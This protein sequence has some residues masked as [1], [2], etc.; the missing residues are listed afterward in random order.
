MQVIEVQV[1]GLHGH[2]DA[3]FALRDRLTLLTG[4]NG[5]GKTSI[6]RAINALLALDL[7]ELW[8]LEFVR[9]GV[10][11]IADE[12]AQWLRVHKGDGYLRF[13]I[14]HLAESFEL[15]RRIISVHEGREISEGVEY[16]TASH[17]RIRY[18]RRYFQKHIKKPIYVDLERRLDD[19]S[20]P[21]RHRSRFSRTERGDDPKPISAAVRL[22]Q[23]AHS[24]TRAASQGLLEE[25]K[26]KMILIAMERPTASPTL[27]IDI[28]G[29]RR[30]VNHRKEI[31]RTLVSTGV[32]EPELAQ[33]LDELSADCA[34]LLKELDTTSE[35]LHSLLTS[36][37][38]RLQQLAVR[39]YVLEDQIAR[40]NRVI[41]AVKEF[42]ER[43]SSVEQPVDYYKELVNSFIRESGKEIHFNEKGRLVLVLPNGRSLRPHELSSGEKQVVTILTHLLFNR[44]TLRGRLLAIDEPELSLHISWQEKFVPALL[45]ATERDG[46]QL[47]LA[48]HSPAIIGD[49]VA[50]CVDVREI[51]DPGM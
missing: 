35:P 34:E 4:I 20:D 3:R 11:V 18:L 27:D 49:R 16:E 2:I 32:G 33:S 42:S 21:F 6:L 17:E 45:S 22:A 15:R 37:D 8:S 31:E 19:L 40:V 14:E 43:S 36:K 41:T 26:R 50:S 48:T 39:Y 9:L 46:S 38:N 51:Y 47:L 24:E 10:N 23:E 7:E 29:M 12:R 5:S 44:D 25:L 1:A 30:I 13:E 28:D